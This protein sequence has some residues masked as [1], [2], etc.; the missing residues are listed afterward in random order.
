MSNGKDRRRVKGENGKPDNEVVNLHQL[1]CLGN[2]VHILDQRLPRLA[3][4]V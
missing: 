1:E 4:L 3:M 2:V